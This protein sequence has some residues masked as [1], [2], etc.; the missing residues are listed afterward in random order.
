MRIRPYKIVAILIVVALIGFYILSPITKAASTM[1]FLINGAD[2]TALGVGVPGTTYN[3]VAPT[4]QSSW[5]T[6]Q[7][8]R[9]SP[10]AGAM[11]LT[12][13]VVRISTAPG[14]GDTRVFTVMV[15]G[16]ATAATVTISGTD[17]QN[18]ATFSV[19]VTAGQTISLRAEAT[20]APDDTTDVY[21]SILAESVSTAYFVMFGGSGTTNGVTA[22]QQVQNSAGAWSTSAA[23]ANQVMP[24][25]GNITAWYVT[26]TVAPGTG[27]DAWDISIAVNGT[28]SAATVN[29]GAADTGLK[30]WTGTVAL[31][32]S[33]LVAMSMVETGTAAVTAVAWSSVITP[34]TAGQ[35][36]IMFG[37]A[38]PPLVTGAT[39]YEQ[40]LGGGNNS[41]IGTEAN[42]FATLY[43]ATLQALYVSVGTAPGVGASWTFQMREETADFTGVAVTVSD[44]N[45]TNSATFSVTTTSGNRYNWSSVPSATDPAA[46]TGGV[47]IGLL[48]FFAT[49]SDS[50]P[51]GIVQLRTSTQLRTSVQFR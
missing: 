12:G 14:A 11:T 45:T 43:T 32:A 16:V 40:I 20:G 51:V 25:A 33:D 49:A 27:S 37:S 26:S 17:V 2:N 19:S 31:V 38:D 8:N 6:T 7:T 15:D 39:E 36:A 41:W 22:Y 34:T 44:A 29:Y 10:V 35:S 4:H 1:Q 30:T 24:L 42:R 48:V 28:P 47:H 3:F 46:M 5:N 50:S 23:A 9:D 18:S 21:W 13:M